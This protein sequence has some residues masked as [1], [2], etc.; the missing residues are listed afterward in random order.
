MVAEQ[1]TDR[2]TA[3]LGYL[4]RGWSVIPIEARG[5]RPLVAWRPFQSRLATVAAVE[6]WFQRWPE[7]NVGL[8]TGRVSGLVVLDVDARHGGTESLAALEQ[9]HGVLPVTLE[10]S[11]GGGG[12]HLYFRHPGPAVMNRVGLRPG[13][14][15]RGDGGCVVAPPSV[16]PSGRRYAW[17][18]GR[19]P[20]E[21]RL[22][23]LPHWLAVPPD[24]A[25][26]GHAPAHWR[27]LVRAGVAEGQRNA[28]L[29]SL[30]GHLLA[31]AVDPEVA[32]ELLLAWNRVRCRPPLGDAE[33]ARVVDSITRLHERAH[34]AGPG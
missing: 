30:S 5:K 21:A 9:A 17:L 19:S 32:L 27:S 31:H 13:I 23:S 11:T 29:A 33:V 18:A 3:A 24:A 15:L 26:Q 7:A 10:A 6:D 34:G 8:V 2:L 4:R 1:E 25:H 14:D 12:R 20:D 22:A 28:S 16:H